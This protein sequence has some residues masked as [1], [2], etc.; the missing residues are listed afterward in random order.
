MV[1]R[2]FF[3]ISSNASVACPLGAKEDHISIQRV[4]RN[5][6]RFIMPA[7]MISLR[8]V[9][10]YEVITDVQLQEAISK[11]TVLISCAQAVID[12]PAGDMVPLQVRQFDA[13]KLKKYMDD[14][15]FYMGEFQEEPLTYQKILM[16]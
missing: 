14:L 7:E 10:P 11:L 2:S 4:M 6:G 5:L 1:R 3:L 8:S 12:Q 9:N 16:D 13:E 15:V